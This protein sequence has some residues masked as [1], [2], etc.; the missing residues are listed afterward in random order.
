MNLR[1]FYKIFFILSSVFYLSST[2]AA[3]YP[4][5]ADG[6]SVIGSV[7]TI[8][9]KK[10]DSI[11]SLRMNYE[12]SLVD[13]LAANP[14]LQHHR[15]HV[16]DV[17]VIPSQYVLPIYQKGIV[18]NMPELH[19]YY[20]SPDGRYVYVF[21]VAM[22]RPNWRT[23]TMATKITS[24]ETDP[25]WY[26]PKSVH[27]YML[28]AHDLDLPPV[29]LPGEKNPLGKYALYLAKPGYLIHGT[30]EPTSVGTFASSGCMRLSST[31]I[32]LLYEETPIGTPV[33]IIHHAIKVGWL[34]GKLYMEAHTP[35]ELDQPETS[36]NS[37]NTEN[38]ID[39]ALRTRPAVIDWDMVHK[40]VDEHDGVPHVI[41]QEAKL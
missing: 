39:Q 34:N 1:F 22:G 24:K 21:P 12:L 37:V 9:A 33:Y 41:S 3:A 26:V 25:I 19:L 8:Q 10:G 5:P 14:K 2:F 20:F 31:A 29:V 23:P 11:K 32:Q 17:L 13:V 18:L 40:V 38:A 7:F 4:M 30:N 36:L 6:D 35:I 15:L 16:G 28:E 27:D